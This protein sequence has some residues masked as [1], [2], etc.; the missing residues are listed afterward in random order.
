M[1]TS[2]SSEIS[3]PTSHCFENTS[4]FNGCSDMTKSCPDEIPTKT[5]TF[6][7]FRFFPTC[8][9]YFGNSCFMLHLRT[10][11]NNRARGGNCVTITDDT[12]DM[13]MFMNRNVFLMSD[14]TCLLFSSWTA[15]LPTVWVA[16]LEHCLLF[17]LL[18]LPPPIYNLDH[19]PS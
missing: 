13:F 18:L 15:R 19:S 8:F 4:A 9:V 3:H 1:Y 17:T 16:C 2:T 5:T 14:D 10:G 7:C 6:I 11:P 12:T